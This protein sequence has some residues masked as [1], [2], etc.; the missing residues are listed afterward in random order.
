LAA[1]GIGISHCGQ[2]LVVTGTGGLGI[3]LFTA[4]TITKIA[5]AT[6]R[7]LMMVLRKIP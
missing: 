4:R 1:T 2:G 3:H 5:K 7:K 6:I